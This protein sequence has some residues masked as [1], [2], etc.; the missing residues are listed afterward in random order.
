MN[1]TTPPYEQLYMDHQRVLAE[2]YKDCEL[3][4]AQLADL[5]NINNE[6]EQ[7]LAKAH[8]ALRGIEN[9]VAKPKD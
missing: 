5:H 9:N 7:D 4:H 3:L 1:D 8:E 2:W 6:L